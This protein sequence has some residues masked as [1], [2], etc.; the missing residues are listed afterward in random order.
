MAKEIDT[1]YNKDRWYH[2]ESVRGQSYMVGGVLI[3]FTG[4]G[5]IIGIPLAIWGWSKYSNAPGPITDVEI[6]E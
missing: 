3:S 5:A 6:E 2:Q 1:S 4:V